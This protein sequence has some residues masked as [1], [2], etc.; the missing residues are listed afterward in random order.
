MTPITRPVL[1]T[2]VQVLVAVCGALPAAVALL[3]VSAADTEWVLG[4]AGA[5][6][7]IVTA[8][9]NA[10][11]ARGVIPTLGGDPSSSGTGDE[12]EG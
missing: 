5:L 1:R 6:V 2:F 7:V 8:V 10:L 9:Q 4:I 3:P 11:E 12:L